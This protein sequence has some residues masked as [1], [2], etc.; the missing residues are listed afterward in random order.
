M[1]VDRAAGG[2]DRLD[3]GERGVAA[4]DAGELALDHRRR[5]PLAGRLEALED[6]ALEPVPVGRERRDVGI[7][8]VGLGG[9]VEQVEDPAATPWRGRP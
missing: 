5:G 3:R 9:E 4:F 1:V 7:V 8:P 2:L 6:G